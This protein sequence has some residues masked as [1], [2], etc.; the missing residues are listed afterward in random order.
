M[1]ISTHRRQSDDRALCLAGRP[2]KFVPT[3]TEGQCREIIR[4]W[5]KDAVLVPFDYDSPTM[6]KSVRGLKVDKAKRPY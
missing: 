2:Q 3:K 1:E 6:R 4:T 5:V